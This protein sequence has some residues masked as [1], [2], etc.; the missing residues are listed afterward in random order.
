[1]DHP[2]EHSL[3]KEL[4]ISIKNHDLKMVK[5][6]IKYTDFS[7]N[8]RNSY[9][10]SPL[11]AA[12]AEGS[13]EI[14]EFLIQNGANLADI[15]NDGKNGAMIACTTGNYEM[16]RKLLQFTVHLDQR[17]NNGS[18]C[19]MIA[20]S[21]GHAKICFELIKRGATLLEEALFC[22]VKSNHLNVV[23]TLLFNGANVDV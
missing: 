20:A 22:A 12:V 4:F 6:I 3:I 23:K 11:L 18:T 5:T 15:T 13:I 9:G 7:T 1:M 2:D 10:N 19:L 8:L 21:L 17:A 14:V 16:L